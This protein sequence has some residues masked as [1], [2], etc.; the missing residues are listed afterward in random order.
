MRRPRGDLVRGVAMSRYDTG[1]RQ[2]TRL[3]DAGLRI[4]ELPTLRDIDTI[5]DLKAV[6]AMLDHPADLWPADVAGA[7]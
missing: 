4:L 3:L 6:S 1:D 5:D 7:R 2:R